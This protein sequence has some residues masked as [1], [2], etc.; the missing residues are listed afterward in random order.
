MLGDVVRS[1]RALAAETADRLRLTDEER[2]AEAAARVAADRLRIAR[3]LHD[4]VAHSMATITVQAGSALHLLGEGEAGGTRPTGIR[5]ALVAIRDT[6]KSAL[7]EMR[8]TLGPDV[9]LMDLKM[10][11]VDGVTATRRITSDPQLASVRVVVLTT[12]DDDESVVAAVRA[13]AYRFLHKDTEPDELL[14]A[15]RVV[16]GGDAL[17]A[18]SVT[19]AVIGAL[20]A[21]GPG[22]S[23]ASQA[24]ARAAASRA[25]G[26]APRGR[27]ADRPRAGGGG[28]GGRGPVQ[29]RDR[30]HAGGQPAD[31]QD[32]RQPGHDQARRA[33]PGPARRDRLRQRPGRAGEP[34][35]PLIRPPAGPHQNVTAHGFPGGS[36]VT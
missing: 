27:G 1:R 28:P 4:T 9:V 25:A 21:A 17:L 5:E 15:I 6:S 7:A 29:R 12:F 36:R 34:A 3:E 10:P 31:R 32:S 19:R 18:P 20:T 24:G 33:G 8:V 30:R 16:A 23:G 26:P 35:G 13:G 22:G 11:E 14:Q 2:E